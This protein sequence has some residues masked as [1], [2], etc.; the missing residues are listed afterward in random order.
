MFNIFTCRELYS[1]GSPEKISN[2]LDM[3]AKNKIDY[4]IEFPMT[5]DNGINNVPYSILVDGKDFEEASYFLRRASD[6]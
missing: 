6:A 2:V 3:L 4:K 5:S 1:S